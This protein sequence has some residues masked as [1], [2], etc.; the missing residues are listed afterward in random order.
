MGVEVAA[1]VVRHDASDGLCDGLTGAAVLDVLEEG[2]KLAVTL[3][4]V[5]LLDLLLVPHGVDFIE[6]V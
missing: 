4:R 5:L 1:L 3:R 6:G 2:G